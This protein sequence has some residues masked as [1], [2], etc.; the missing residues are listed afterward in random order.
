MYTGENR[1]ALQSRAWLIEALWALME[2]MPYQKISVKGICARAD[3]S[4]QT[5]YH[6]F[7]QKA[8]ILSF[9]VA[10]RYQ[11]TLLRL[12]KTKAVFLVEV[13]EILS[14]FFVQNRVKLRLLIAQG[15]EEILRQGIAAA[16]SDF[17]RKMVSTCQKKQV[18]SYVNAFCTGG[19]V[20]AL[21]CWFKEDAPLCP[22]KFSA[23]LQQLLP[24]LGTAWP[25]I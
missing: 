14:D 24:T 16:L 4:R 23:L 18:C 10:Q 1:I 21:I 12:E 25:G 15:Q 22:E 11:E 13:T 9:W 3:L 5:F 7:N 2:E 8:D 6:F 19:I 20:Q 17:S